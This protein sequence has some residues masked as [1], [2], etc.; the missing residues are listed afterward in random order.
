M[1]VS[2]RASAGQLPLPGRAPPPTPGHGHFPGPSALPVTRASSVLQKCT[3]DAPMNQTLSTPW[4][5]TGAPSLQNRHPP[6]TCH[7]V[8]HSQDLP[9]AASGF[10]HPPTHTCGPAGEGTPRVLGSSG[11]Q[12]LT[13]AQ[14][15][16]SSR[17]AQAQI[18]EFS[19]EKKEGSRSI[20]W[21]P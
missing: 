2:S 11:A 8:H 4:R 19:Q 14:T 15:S 16:K 20:L 12:S 21:S 13:H 5:D 7:H 9:G 10:R 18:I 17:R 1:C 6:G 3:V